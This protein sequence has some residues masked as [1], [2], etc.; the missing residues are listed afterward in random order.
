MYYRQEVQVQHVPAVYQVL[1]VVHHVILCT[2][3]NLVHLKAGQADP[4]AIVVI[5]IRNKIVLS[6]LILQNTTPL[7]LLNR[8]GQVCIFY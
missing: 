3:T 4:H 8:E 1:H 2:L 5:Q 7:N 6:K